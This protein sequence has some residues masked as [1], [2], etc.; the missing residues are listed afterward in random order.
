MELQELPAIPRTLRHHELRAL[1][2]FDARSAALLIVV[3][4]VLVL[5]VVQ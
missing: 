5:I 4:V 1:F 3:S 2:K